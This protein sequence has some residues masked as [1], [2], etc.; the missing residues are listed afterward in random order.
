MS[1]PR[2]GTITLPTEAM[3]GAERG[4]DSREARRVT[5]Q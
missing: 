4:D 2:S 1:D 5:A 3:R